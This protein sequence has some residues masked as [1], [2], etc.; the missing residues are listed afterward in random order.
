MTGAGEEHVHFASFVCRVGNG[1]IFSRAPFLQIHDY[2]Y[3][4]HD[5]YNISAQSQGAWRLNGG[6]AIQ[7]RISMRFCG[8]QPLAFLCKTT[9][10]TLAGY[11][12][13]YSDQ[14]TERRGWEWV[15]P[16]PTASTSK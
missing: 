11:N 7:G 14:H 15:S 3:R 13:P 9:T 5:P 1:D 10:L 2:G 16:G 6:D 8:G 4:G 12:Y